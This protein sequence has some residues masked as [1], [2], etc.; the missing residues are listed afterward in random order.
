[1]LMHSNCLKDLSPGE[2]PRVSLQQ[3]L[4]THASWFQ[5]CCGINMC[6][7]SLDLLHSEQTSAGRFPDILRLYSNQQKCCLINISLSLQL[8]LCLRRSP[9]LFRAS[10]YSGRHGL[11]QFTAGL[12]WR[13]L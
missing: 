8:H 3:S 7:S 12:E 9:F 11:V 13:S 6:I 2:S 4:S 5:R 10:T 1:N